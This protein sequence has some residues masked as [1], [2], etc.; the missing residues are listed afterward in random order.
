MGNQQR[1][2]E[3][4]TRQLQALELRKAGVTYEGIAKQLGYKSPEAVFQ[5]VKA[6][7]K[8]SLN[9]PANEIREME[10]KRLDDMLLAMWPQVK[11]GNQGAVDRSLRIMERRA[12][13]LGLDA[14]TKIA[15]TDPTGEH[16]YRDLSD[17]ERLEQIQR[18]LDAARER[19]GGQVTPDGS[20]S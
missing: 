5:A 10:V 1:K 9:E 2:V 15:P 8:S 17:N 20:G 16:E 4:H 18:I 6:A 3:A 14:P 19:A 11:N 12:R 7:M 13:L